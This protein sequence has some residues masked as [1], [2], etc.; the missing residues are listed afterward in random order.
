MGTQTHTL[1]DAAHFC[2]GASK[3]RG[4]TKGGFVPSGA[5][6]EEHVRGHGVFWSRRPSFA[7]SDIGKADLFWMASDHS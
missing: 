5:L 3:R 4:D 6:P 1:E 7:K 2:L